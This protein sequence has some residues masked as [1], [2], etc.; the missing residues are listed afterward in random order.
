MQDCYLYSVLV[1]FWL[2]LVL[3]SSLIV[4]SF[5]C[6]QFWFSLALIAF[7]LDCLITVLMA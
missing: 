1:Y 5:G 6:I 7:S 3:G 2:Y 4:F